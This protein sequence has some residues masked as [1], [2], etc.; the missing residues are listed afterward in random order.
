MNAK[1]QVPPSKMKKEDEDEI[2]R[3]K[4]ELA[5]QRQRRLDQERLASNIKMGVGVATSVA[6]GLFAL[7][8]LKKQLEMHETKNVEISQLKTEVDN[9]DVLLK[10][11]KL[12]TGTVGLL[13]GVSALVG[14]YSTWITNNMP[15]SF[16]KGQADVAAETK[17]FAEQA[18]FKAE[19]NTTAESIKT[20]HEQLSGIS[21]YFNDLIAYQSAPKP[22]QQFPQTIPTLDFDDA[23]PNKPIGPWQEF[24]EIVWETKRNPRD[25][26][27]YKVGSKQKAYRF[28]EQPD[29]L[30]RYALDDI[31]NP[32]LNDPA[33]TVNYNVIKDPEGWVSYERKPPD[34]NKIYNAASSLNQVTGQAFNSPVTRG[35]FQAAVQYYLNSK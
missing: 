31:T 24:K 25:G 28:G 21:G 10:K 27:T 3:Q 7:Y 1:A 19:L 13:A 5:K 30:K 2:E 11:Q 23:N 33:L 29:I 9:L 12:G 15:A 32:L 26:G 8:K 17:A 20:H 6:T 16:R 4:V 18:A 14:R 34:I 22:T 35:I